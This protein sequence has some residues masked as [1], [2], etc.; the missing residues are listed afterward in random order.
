MTLGLIWLLIPASFHQ[1]AEGGEDTT[2]I[3]RITTQVLDW[4]LLPFAFGLA[5]S[6]YVISSFMGI[7]QP[8]LMAAF[9]GL[10][11][12]SWW[13]LL[14]LAKY[15]SS[16]RV[17]VA[18]ELKQE[19]EKQ[20]KQIGGT[21]IKEKIKKL[22][23]EC[24]MVLP[25][26]QAMLGFQL[27]TFFMPGFARLSPSS[28]WIH[29]GGLMATAI[30]TFLVITPAAYHRLAEAGE[31]TE[32]LHQVG[33]K[34]VGCDVF[35]GHRPERG[36]RGHSLQSGDLAILVLCDRIDVS[37]LLL[38]AL[39]RCNAPRKQQVWLA[40]PTEVLPLSNLLLWPA[41]PDNLQSL[42]NIYLAGPRI[43]ARREACVTRRFFLCTLVLCALSAVVFAAEKTELLPAG[44]LLTCTVDEPNL[45]SKTAQVGDP[46]LCHLGTTTT[47]GRQA[48]P[49]GSYLTGRL[50]DYRDPGH[51]YGKGWL[52]IQFDRLVLP[53]EGE[54]SL[55]AKLVSVPRYK[56]DRDGKLDGKGHAKRDVIEWM[57][58]VLWPIK[59]LTLP[60]RGPYPT[61]KGEVRITMRLMEDIILPAP[62]TNATVRP[63][64][65]P[66]WAQPSS[67]L[68]APEP[69]YRRARAG[70]RRQQE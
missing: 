4:G 49:R 54:V 55:A 5:I 6:G 32:H 53:G 50:D 66:P 22:L 8:G 46:I 56:V 43:R 10:F 58:P 37:V 20:R 24:R 19:E 21:D 34:L 16:K 28:Q 23:I 18:R 39:V 3:Y 29:C 45:S 59:V 12:L 41:T 63:V 7:R 70:E 42:W 47:L 36:F 64:P 2:R 65:M 48:F 67:I 13:Y 11:A 27:T 52:S 31:D 60:A 68:R 57:V 62:V 51:F 25:G 14:A 17:S 35:S 26:V 38:R 44:L 61:L 69:D 30:A 15:D 33:T 9:V 1:L 40:A